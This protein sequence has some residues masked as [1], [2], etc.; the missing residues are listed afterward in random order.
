M[1]AFSSA[2][3][4]KDAVSPGMVELVSSPVSLKTVVFPSGGV[5]WWLFS[6]AKS[7]S[8]SG[9]VE[10]IPGEGCLFPSSSAI[11]QQDGRLEFCRVP[12]QSASSSPVESPEGD[13]FYA[14]II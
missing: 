14:F 13:T 2:A 9:S 12:Q 4:L 10:V 8:G 11:P 6:P 3:S 7:P 1:V 5:R